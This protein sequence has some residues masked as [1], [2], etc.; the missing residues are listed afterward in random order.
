M[1]ALVTSWYVAIDSDRTSHMRVTEYNTI[2]PA[3]KKTNLAAAPL[4][5]CV[6]PPRPQGLGARGRGFSTSDD[7]S[8]IGVRIRLSAPAQEGVA[9]GGPAKNHR[10]GKDR[11]H[12]R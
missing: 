12:T 4:E 2:L 10:P 9:L 3:L 6:N 8:V 5:A 7:L 1:L 11:H